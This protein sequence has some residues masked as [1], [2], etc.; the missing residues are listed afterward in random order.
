[1]HKPDKSIRPPA[2]TKAGII[3]DLNQKSRQI[4]GY[5]GFG[6]GLTLNSQS[7]SVRSSLL[8]LT[9]WEQT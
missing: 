9:Q 3:Q 8:I 7:I 4:C 2:N 5:Y 1:M 6:G